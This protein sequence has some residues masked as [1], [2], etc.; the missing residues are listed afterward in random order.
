[1]SRRRASPYEVP[2][3]S[4]A[5]DRGKQSQYTTLDKGPGRPSTR[6]KPSSGNTR[7]GFI[8]EAAK[9]T[10]DST[11]SNKDIVSFTL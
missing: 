2:L 6:F 8:M 4:P 10:H 9:P 11:S 1:M 3:W 7:L 5:F